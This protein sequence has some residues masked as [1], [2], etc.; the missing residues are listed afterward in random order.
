M[1]VRLVQLLH[2][3]HGRAVALVDEPFLR[4]LPGWFSAFALAQEAIESAQR[5]SQIISR[6]PPSQSFQYEQIYHGR[7]DW[8][9][10][11][12]VDH[13]DQPSRCLITGTG[14]THKASAENRQS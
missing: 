3:E 9:L 10:L 1:A 8:K 2:Q 5:I 6:V 12:A 11:P 13:P 14:L 7:S 4:I